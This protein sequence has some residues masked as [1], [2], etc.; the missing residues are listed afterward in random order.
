MID[1]ALMS[2][3]LDA[4]PP[5]TRLILLGDK[6]QLASVEAGAVLGD[7]CAGSDGFSAH[8]Q[9]ELETL[10]EQTLPAAPTTTAAMADSIVLL[11]HSY[12]FDARSGI[13]ALAYAVNTGQSQT[14]LS[15]LHQGHND[16]HWRE[17]NS[18]TE[19]SRALP[20]TVS[21][22]LRH[23]RRCLQTDPLDIDELFSAFSQFR[24][25][26]ALRNGPY[27]VLELNRL[28]EQQILG[29]ALSERSAEPW[30]QG[31]PVM[32]T[33]NDYN[34]RLYN[35]DIGIALP[36]PTDNHRLKVVFRTEDG[37]L[38]RLLPSRLPGYET[39]YAMTVHKSQGSEFDQVLLI[40]PGDDS[41]VLTRELIYTGITR[42]RQR[43]EIWGRSSVFAA[44]IERRLQRSSGLRDALWAQDD[45]Y[46]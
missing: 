11:R 43:V 22:G 23:Y 31:R 34:L 30:Y 17:F 16:I 6:D 7:I 24:I 19:L 13:G 5:R 45:P 41:R 21:T 35:G 15:L 29:Y 33:R 36:D 20:T 25:L 12:R 9:R 28:I 32:I 10:T 46:A 44:A 4:L 40:L 18:A 2:K 27:G 14:S 42:A 37:Q 38:R 8:F 39:V 1:L 26:C 3:L